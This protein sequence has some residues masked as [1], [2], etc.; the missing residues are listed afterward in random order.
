[1]KKEQLKLQMAYE[2]PTV[3]VI[4]VEVESGFAASVGDPNDYES[5]GSLNP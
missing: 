2:A 5:G 1:M 4:E 3:E